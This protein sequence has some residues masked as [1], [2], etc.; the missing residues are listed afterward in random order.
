MIPDVRGYDFSALAS[1]FD[2]ID[3]VIGIRRVR[4]FQMQIDK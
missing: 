1:E 4:D 3:V 2:E